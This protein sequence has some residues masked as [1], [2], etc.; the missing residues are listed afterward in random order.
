[1]KHKE[2]SLGVR[3]AENLG[4]YVEHVLKAMGCSRK[5]WRWNGL[6]WKWEGMNVRWPGRH[7]G[8][9]CHSPRER[10]WRSGPQR[11]RKSEWCFR[12]QI[13]YLW[14][15]NRTWEESKMTQSFQ[16]QVIMGGGGGPPGQEAHKGHPGG[17]IPP[18]IGMWN[19][20]EKSSHIGEKKNNV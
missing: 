2:S 11:G 10:W 19:S 16:T 15:W 17:D 20:G 14:E 7:L 3:T 12:G 6:S 8:H 9:H 13:T 18:V 4:G 5:V 1:M